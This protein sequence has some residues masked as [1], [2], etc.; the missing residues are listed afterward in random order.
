M[1]LLELGERQAAILL[2]EL[3][4]EKDKKVTANKGG[5]SSSYTS[6]ENSLDASL[7][8]I[9]RL[10][11]AISGQNPDLGEILS[12]L[13][14]VLGLLRMDKP[15]LT[16]LQA[17]NA[18][19]S[20]HVSQLIWFIPL[21]PSQ[22]HVWTRFLHLYFSI[23]D[24][25]TAVM[26]ISNSQPSSTRNFI[27]ILA[28]GM[29]KCIDTGR[30]ISVVSKANSIG[31]ISLM[32]EAMIKHDRFDQMSACI[33]GM[34]GP[35]VDT[36]LREL[37]HGLYTSFSELELFDRIS[38][39]LFDCELEC[40]QAFRRI[41]LD[42]PAS[43]LSCILHLQ[44]KSTTADLMRSLL[45][46]WTIRCDLRKM[47]LHRQRQVTRL[48][49]V[50]M[51]YC[52]MDSVNVNGL[53]GLLMD[54]IQ[55]RLN[56][57]DEELA[58][59]GKVVAECFGI[60]SPTETRLSFELTGPLVEDFRGCFSYGQM[61]SELIGQ[62]DSLP[63]VKG[64]LDWMPVI[65]SLPTIEDHE[66]T[67]PVIKG[68]APKVISGDLRP[69]MRITCE[70]EEP[71]N[72][73]VKRPRFLRDVLAYLKCTDDPNK[74]E[75]ALSEI[76]GLLASSST[77]LKEEIGL[78]LYRCILYLG[79]DFNIPNF[80][81]RRRDALGY[82]VCDIPHIVGKSVLREICGRSA[83][84]RMKLEAIT[85]CM[86]ALRDCISITNDTSPA[87][88][89]GMYLLE[90]QM[91]FSTKSL[92]RPSSKIREIIR[93]VIDPL[94]ATLQ[95][96]NAKIFGHSSNELFLE[97]TLY[98]IAFSVTRASALPECPHLLQQTISFILPLLS[99]ESLPRPILKA[100]IVTM[101]STLSAWPSGL[102]VLTHVDDFMAI[103][104][105]IEGSEQLADL[106]QDYLILA[107]S[108]MSFIQDRMDPIKLLNEAATTMAVNSNDLR[109]R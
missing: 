56:S 67:E 18:L 39:F 72:A 31:G 90:Q 51:S 62:R 97:R 71:R 65:K 2:E 99:S 109:L 107:G 64:E 104:K 42:C 69:I 25:L 16:L 89:I 30:V 58:L 24:R 43:I 13:S 101:Q 66:S 22:P 60:I 11:K 38:K 3:A 68:I 46:I 37:L 93:N 82:L 105:F 75:L 85:S 63:F 92:A 7:E 81:E 88:H 79:E 76:G 41:L 28:T 95:N 4:T 15:T 102:S 23:P 10:N 96:A 27:R 35:C 33:T 40:S 52:S 59:M 106:E 100:L 74:L 91:G 57:S 45:D 103:A 53:E 8:C 44:P 36:F 20:L 77:L 50:A 1:T 9:V 14:Q 73:K 61:L 21:P 78:D 54:G 55:R 6:L 87:V 47:P 70:D 84:L 86:A 5:T 32:T 48:L 49:L 29:L 17:M 19:E 12:Y 83:S 98:L 34:I 80:D 108:T 26:E 94:M